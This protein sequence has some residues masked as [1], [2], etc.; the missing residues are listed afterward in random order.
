MN[1]TPTERRF[2]EIF[3]LTKAYPNPF[4]DD[5]VVVEDFNLILRRGELVS[6]IGH[7]GCGKSTVLTMLAGLNPITS[8][9]LAVA[10]REVSGPGPDRAVVFQS[11]CLLPWMTALQNVRL[12]V[13]RI[14]PHAS[15]TER[16]ELCAYYL[17]LVGLGESL[18]KYPREMSG[19]MQQRVGIARAIALRPD[20][21]L[22]DEPFGRLDSLTRMELQDVILAI[23]DQERITTMLVTHDVDEALF[24]SDRICMMT[25]G[26]KARVGQILEMPL[27]RPRNRAETLG[28]PLYY[29]LRGCLVDFLERQELRKHQAA[30][31]KKSETNEETTQHQT[32]ANRQL[33][34]VA[35]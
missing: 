13:D 25:N 12:G 7:S 3:R 14:Y 17:A 34:E 8:G 18:H 5:V 6:L 19:G 16:R 24:M 2:V 9:S 31:P 35:G 30:V 26:P 27:E 29:D 23:L 33:S 32:S 20:V 4:G 22:L 15:K 1:Q 11:P 10:G 28:H 21:L